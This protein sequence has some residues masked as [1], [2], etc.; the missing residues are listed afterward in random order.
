MRIK[1]GFL[2]RALAGAQVV[3][4]TGDVA[5]DFSGMI[6][7][8]GTGA[9]L[10]E[11]LARE[12]SEEQLLQAMLAEYDVDAIKARTDITDFLTKLKA[13]DLLA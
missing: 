12:Q 2:L 7:L 8:N 9:F 11:Q 10:W 4:P 5:L 1:P 3:V 6:S 13:A